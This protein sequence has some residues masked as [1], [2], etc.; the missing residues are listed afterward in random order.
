M[1][2]TWHPEHFVCTHCQDE[3]GSRN[4]FEREGQPYCE[5][6]YHHL[7]SPR[8]HYCNGPILDVSNAY[9]NTHTYTHTYTHHGWMDNDI[10]LF[11]T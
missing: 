8:C 4:F 6:D 5:K 2:R 11:I 3:I 10:Y 9:I 7:F 1:G